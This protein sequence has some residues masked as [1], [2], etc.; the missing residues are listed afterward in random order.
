MTARP[1][2][3]PVGG[4]QRIFGISGIA[5]GYEAR[6]PRRTDGDQFVGK[7][8]PIPTSWYPDR[9]TNLVPLSG[10]LAGSWFGADKT[11]AR[12]LS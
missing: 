5:E 11:G 1:D 2:A 12:R 10:C 8:L 6:R 3:A 9:Y 7:I 4:P